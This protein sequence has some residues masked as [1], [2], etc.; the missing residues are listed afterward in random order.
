MYPT[1]PYK[2]PEATDAPPSEH[3][4]RLFTP[5]QAGVATFLGSAAAGG[6]VLGLNAWRLGKPMHAVAYGVGGVA[7]LALLIFV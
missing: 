2:A 4:P 1:N 5:K 3:A 7:V 6:V